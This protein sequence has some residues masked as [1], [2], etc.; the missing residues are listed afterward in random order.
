MIVI[1][2]V[3]QPPSRLADPPWSSAFPVGEDLVLCDGRGVALQTRR[4]RRRNGGLGGLERLRGEVTHAEVWAEGGGAAVVAGLLRSGHLFAWDPSK[5]ARG[6]LTLIRGLP[7]F[8]SRR[9]PEEEEEAGTRRRCCCGDEVVHA[10]DDDGGGGADACYVR[11]AATTALVRKEGRLYLWRLH[12]GGG[13]E[14]G[15][16]ERGPAHAVLTGSWCEVAA[17][18][19][20]A[21]AFAAGPSSSPGCWR[22]WT[23]ATVSSERAGPVQCTVDRV[24]AV[25]AKGLPGCLPERVAGTTASLTAASDIPD[26]TLVSM[27]CRVS[28][29]ASVVLVACNFEDP[30]HNRK[31]TIRGRFSFFFKQSTCIN[32]NHP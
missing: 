13:V 6:D 9:D 22:W 10:Y 15:H 1:P 16:P 31:V 11:V 5:T 19:P 8:A 18:S 17:R 7:Q 25:S 20:P 32:V 26:R 4:R 28:N 23:V 2:V 12:Q 24:R 3:P 27:V 21:L 14:R 29:D 30:L